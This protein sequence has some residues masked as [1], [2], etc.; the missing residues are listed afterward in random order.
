VDTTHG[1]RRSAG[2][3]AG[4]GSIATVGDRVWYIVQAQLPFVAIL[5]VVTAGLAVVDSSHIVA[6]SYL[7]AVVLAVA[8]TGVALVLP[9]ERIS[10]PWVWAISL[11]DFAVV[12][13]LGETLSE[14]FPA[15]IVLV[16]F[17][18]MW[19]AYEFGIRAVPYSLAASVIAVLFPHLGAGTWAVS[20]IDVAGLTV[21]AAFILLF[22][23]SVG[24][25]SDLLRASRRMVG[26][27][28]AELRALLAASEDRELTLRAVIDTVD[29]AIVVFDTQGAVITTNETASS[30]YEKSSTGADASGG[31]EGLIFRRDRHTPVSRSDGIIARALRDEP[32]AGR[33]YWLGEGDGQVAVT[34]GARRVHR[35]DGEV[36]GTVIV[37]HEVTALVEAVSVRDDFLSSV[38]HELKTPLTNIIG[39]LEVI[40]GAAPSIAGELTIIQKNADRLLALVTQLLSAAGTSTAV[41]RLPADV[42]DIVARKVASFREAASAKD[43]T[44]AEPSSPSIIAEVDPNAL[45][46]MVDHLVSNALKFTPAGGHVTVDVLDRDGYAWISVADTGIG[47]ASEH[48]RQVYDRFFRAPLARSGAVPGTGLGLSIVKALVDAHGGVIELTSAPGTGTTIRVGLPLHEITHGH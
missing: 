43:I 24:I 36:L 11:S 14:A 28:S 34:A 15:I 4:P 40:D 2:F 48:Q 22:A 18:V 3:F 27:I 7:W 19:M 31:R 41:H 35:A 6:P 13:L 33:V 32:L 44:F 20:A 26:D 21:R 46:T 8:A 38:S 47:I 17:P 42:S 9:W 5:G 25:M 12:A 45:R 37:A 23:V 16:V 1:Q 30:F 39:Y 29:A 10:R